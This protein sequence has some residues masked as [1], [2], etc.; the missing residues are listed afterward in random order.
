MT[1]KVDIKLVDS[2]VRKLRL[3]R[4]QRKLLHRAIHGQALS[5]REI[6]ELAKEIERDYPRK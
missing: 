3:S 1:R 6:M 5:Y 2:V 4:D